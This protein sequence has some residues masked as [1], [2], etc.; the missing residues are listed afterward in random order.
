MKCPV[1]NEI[2]GT[3]T[4]SRPTKEVWCPN[5]HNYVYNI[6]TCEYFKKNYSTIFQ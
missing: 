2:G 4:N 3:Q 5:G 1:C 6:D